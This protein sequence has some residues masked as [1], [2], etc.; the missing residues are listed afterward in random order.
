MYAD[1]GCFEDGGGNNDP[2]DRDMNGISSMANGNHYPDSEEFYRTGPGFAEMSPEICAEHC[3]G[4]AYFALQHYYRAMRTQTI[5]SY[6]T[7]GEHSD[8]VVC[9]QSASATTQT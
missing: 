9:L 6:L 3:A 4:F 7:P 1:V 5:C 8:S 2:N